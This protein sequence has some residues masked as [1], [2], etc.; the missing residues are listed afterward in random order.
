[1]NRFCLH[2]GAAIDTM[3]PHSPVLT[4]PKCGK[5][6]NN[7]FVPQG[8]AAA[9]K[10]SAASLLLVAVI[11]VP[12]VIAVI[13]ILAAIAIPNFI[14]F[15]A[16]S[17]QVE[18]RTSLL[19]IFTAQEGLRT[20]TGKYTE[21][22]ETLGFEA[23]PKNRYAYFVGPAPAGLMEAQQGTEP[24]PSARQLELLTGSSPGVVDG[25]FTAFCT[26]QLDP[27]PALD[28]WSVSSADRTIDGQRVPGGQPFLH[29]DDVR[30]D[31]LRRK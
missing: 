30:E 24:A 14:R 20:E 3:S 23:P 26:S 22:F 16:K 31:E 5:S 21:S 13:G 7:P 11:A 27:D 2:C 17:K 29:L 4:C 18:C 10:G 28:I 19:Q 15:K 1:M 12:F 25:V 9:G 6:F 8:P